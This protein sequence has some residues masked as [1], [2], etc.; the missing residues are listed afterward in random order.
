VKNKSNSFL[1]PMKNQLICIY[2]QENNYKIALCSCSGLD[3]RYI[4]PQSTTDLTSWEV[5]QMLGGN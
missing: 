3:H 4:Y 1:L 2:P 5:G